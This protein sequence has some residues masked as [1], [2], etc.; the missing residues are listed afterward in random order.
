MCL[1]L[2]LC[3]IQSY[4]NGIASNIVDTS[5]L[6]TYNLA[7]NIKKQNVAN[8]ESNKL[9]EQ[10]NLIVNQ[11]PVPQ[12]QTLNNGPNQVI[13]SFVVAQS[14]LPD[15]HNRQQNQT[16]APTVSRFGRQASSTIHQQLFAESPINILEA[17]SDIL[18][19]LVGH[20]HARCAL[21][22]FL[23]YLLSSSV[24]IL[25]C[26]RLFRMCHWRKPMSSRCKGSAVRAST[27]HN[28]TT[29]GCSNQVDLASYGFYYRTRLGRFLSK[30]LASCSCLFLKPISGTV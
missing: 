7:N 26:L 12:M 11:L 8:N 28:K 4:N 9:E 1:P 24:T 5:D 30:S 18:V 3:F 2:L 15:L 27:A 13:S 23:C 25:I 19:R 20:S 17:N 16:L 6:N 10:T 14:S 22:Y 21:H 29:T